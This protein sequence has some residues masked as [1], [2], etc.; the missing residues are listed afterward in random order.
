MEN[1]VNRYKNLNK[2]I[3]DFNFIC[4]VPTLIEKDY[5][6]G[7]IYRYFL[8]KRNEINGIIY[9]ISKEVKTKLENNPYFLTCEI[10]WKIKGDLNEVQ[11]LNRQS[12]LFGKKTIQHLDQYIN[13][14]N[15]YWKG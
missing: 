9:E 8:I 1:L 3:T 6:I 11:K 14:Y 12:V 5:E 13:N 2:N 15:L 7:Y 4:E 10:R